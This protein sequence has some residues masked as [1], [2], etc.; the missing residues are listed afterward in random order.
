MCVCAHNIRQCKELIL[1]AHVGLVRKF[2]LTKC[3]KYICNV[4]VYIRKVYYIEYQQQIER[5][6]VFI[7]LAKRTLDIRLQSIQLYSKDRFNIVLDTQMICVFSICILESESSL[8]S[9]DY[10]SFLFYF[11]FSF[12][13]Y[14]RVYFKITFVDGN[15]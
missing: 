1:Q 12:I 14:K 6:Y 10:L 8:V 9:F 5:G 7:I 11:F 2:H 13:T 3:L 15:T 4:Y